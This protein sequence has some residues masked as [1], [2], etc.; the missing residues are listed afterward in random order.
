MS[1]KA[2]GFVAF[3]YCLGILACVWTLS[4]SWLNGTVLSADETY[5][6]IVGTLLCFFGLVMCDIAMKWK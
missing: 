4:A 3:L 1:K 5:S 6:Y 2:I